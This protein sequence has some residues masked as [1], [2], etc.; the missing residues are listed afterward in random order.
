[1]TDTHTHL[2]M[3]D[4]YEDGGLA[5]TRRAIEA[6]V[7]RMMFPCVNEASLPEMRRLHAEFPDNT[8][9]ALG[10]H[11]TDLDAN[12]RDTLNRMEQM[13]PGDFKAIGEV[14]IDLY[15]DSSMREQ[16]REAFAIQIG[17]AQRYG[18]PVLI[19]CRE[20][21]DDC[22][23]VISNIE[24]TLPP[25]V[26][27]SFTG[28]VEDV[29]RIRKVCD[30]YFGINGVVTFKNAP[31]LREALPEIGIDRIVLE[32]DSPWLSPAPKRGQTN[33]SSRIPY[34]LDCVAS[35]LGISSEEA[36]RITDANVNTLKLF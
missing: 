17:W 27:H 11:P 25:L 28:N 26:F 21:L 33:E 3:P 9:L 4:V 14:G 5:A 13:L 8:A 35:T 32:T 1:M 31:L 2:Y 7:T 20:A 18:L 23:D 24:G 19:H 22:L 29:R 16:Q 36:E 30:P 12:W 10:L 6:G 34:I 15:H